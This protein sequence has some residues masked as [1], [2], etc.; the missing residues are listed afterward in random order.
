MKPK[1]LHPMLSTGLLLNSLA[2]TLPHVATL[3]DAL[4]GF[5]SGFSVTFL[6]IGA[7]V[8]AGAVKC[9][10]KNSQADGGTYTP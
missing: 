5:I 7:L 8:Q 3:P 2:L 1:K 9:W 4:T 10:H 6:L